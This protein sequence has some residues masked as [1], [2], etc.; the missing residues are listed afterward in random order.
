MNIGSEKQRDHDEKGDADDQHQSQ[1]GHHE[2]DDLLSRQPFVKEQR[3]GGGDEHGRKIVAQR[4]DGHGGVTVGLEKQDP[5]HAHRHAGEE[6]QRGLAPIR[7]QRELLPA[8]EQI[9]ADE[10]RR[11]HRAVKRQLA[12]GNGN[13][14][15][16]RRKRTEDNGRS[17][18]HPTRPP[19]FHESFLPAQKN[20]II[21]KAS[22][23]NASCGTHK[24]R[25]LL[26]PRHRIK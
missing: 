2:A 7:A 17:C 9:A 4:R 6:Q 1:R 11:H 14:A 25:H 13:A 3:A 18:K 26:S 12:R 19:L 24:S 20:V 5:V 16:E 22:P 15:H 10:Q 23:Q 8:H 21:I